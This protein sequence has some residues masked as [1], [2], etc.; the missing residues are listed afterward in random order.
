MHNTDMETEGGKRRDRCILQ[1]RLFLDSKWGKHW[2]GMLSADVD[3]WQWW[4]GRRGEGQ[5]GGC[6]RGPWRK[7]LPWVRKISRVIPTV[8]RTLARAP[9]VLHRNRGHSPVKLYS[10]LHLKHSVQLHEWVIK[11]ETK[12]ESDNR[13]G[14]LSFFKQEKTLNMSLCMSGPFV[15]DYSTTYTLSSPKTSSIS[16]TWDKKA[17]GDNAVSLCTASLTLQHR[18]N[19][20]CSGHLSDT[21]HPV[22][23]WGREGF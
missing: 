8:R 4:K 6:K 19:A 12:L 2:R 9:R 21:Q 10:L 22:S 15:T 5:E 1:T 23:D 13:T 14:T 7:G 17:A 20:I 3:R 11:Q 16:S 18:L